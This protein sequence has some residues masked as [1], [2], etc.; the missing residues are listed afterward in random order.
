MF[1]V[2]VSVKLSHQNLLIEIVKQP[3]LMTNAKK[4]KLYFVELNVFKR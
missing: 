3:G 2:N 4:Q 1:L